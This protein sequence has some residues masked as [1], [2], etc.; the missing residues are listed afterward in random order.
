MHDLVGGDTSYHGPTSALFEETVEDR[1]SQSV[2]RVRK[3]QA[4]M[5]KTLFSSA[6]QQRECI[7][8]I[9]RKNLPQ[10]ATNQWL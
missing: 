7:T 8:F 5:G 1:V 6:A 2:P 9:C 4:D 3:A 10:K